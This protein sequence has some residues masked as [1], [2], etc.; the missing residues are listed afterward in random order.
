MPGTL[1]VAGISSRTCPIA[2]RELLALNRAA[3]GALTVRTAAH[4]GIH[5]ALV[6]S[7]CE[8]TEVYAVAAVPELG[9]ATLRDQLEQLAGPL[10]EREANVASGRDAAQHLMRVAAGLESS[11]PGE[12]EILGQLRG[13]AELARE[14]R[15][16]G[17]VL[18]RLAQD[19]IAAGRRVRETTEI[20]RGRCSLSSVAADLACRFTGG[21][22]ARARALVIGSGDIGSTVA[23]A[24]RAHG[25]QVRLAARH[26]S[27]RAHRLATEIGA[28]TVPPGDRLFE[29]LVETDA[30]ISC[31]GAPHRLVPM[32]AL[33]D[34]AERRRGR[35]LLVI[36]L[37]MPRDF[38]PDASLIDGVRLF[39]LDDLREVVNGTIAQRGAAV[40]A[41]EAIVS[42]ETDRFCRWLTALGAVP[43]IK[44]LHR[45]SERA[46]MAALRRTDLA[47]GAEESVVQAASQTIVSTLLHTP[48]VRLRAAA[49]LGDVAALT[50][51]VRTLFALDP[52]G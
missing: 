2:R 1:V 7:T 32:E 18:D 5:E 51:T 38:D 41:A 16:S 10:E 40:E 29:A 12:F 52:L 20:A 47:S 21:A 4:P 13:A 9:Q 49:E 39:D 37:A 11:V 48:T 3:A 6:L 50:G 46:V 36:D 42:E 44:D 26:R 33:L 31:T 34:V 19:A 14:R 8:R 17:R 23:R 35:P 15:A 25:V 30:V 22:D 43:T 45:E 28:E 24:L 27:E